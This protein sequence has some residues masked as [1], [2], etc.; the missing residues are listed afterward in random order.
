[1]KIIRTLVSS[2][3]LAATFMTPAHASEPD[4]AVSS[5]FTT[6]G[7]FAF[8]DDQKAYIDQVLEETHARVAEFFPELADEVSVTISPVERPALD[9]LG[10]VTGRAER[11]DEL[12][13]ELSQTYPDGVEVAVR[14]GLATT[15]AHELHHTVRGWTMNGNHFGYGIQIAVIN[16]GLATVFA[17]EMLGAVKQSD[18]PPDD[19]EAWVEEVLALPINSNY[20]D[21][22]FLHPD[23]RE[24]IG[25]RTGRWVVRRAMQR[26]G[27]DI[28]QLTA[29]TPTAIWQLAG[30]RWDRQLR[31]DVR[32]NQTER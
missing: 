17:E 6:N 26:S 30:Y 4:G 15:F 3:A 8:A 32:S 13:I 24:A 2:V 23:G 31:P 5:A 16:E 20:G 22:M 18:L 27:L 25:Y 28:V 1:M 7:E 11:P 12:L 10:G 14:D 19:V 9:L 29:L 21:W